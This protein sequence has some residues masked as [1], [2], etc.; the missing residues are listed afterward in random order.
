M[1][2]WQRASLKPGQLYEKYVNKK[3]RFQA[4]MPLFRKNC[5]SPAVP[6]GIPLTTLFADSYSLLLLTL[7]ARPAREFGFSYENRNCQ[8][9]VVG[10]QSPP[11]VFLYNFPVQL[12]ADYYY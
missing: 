1:N 4:C 12:T 2:E 3:Y 6:A 9:S 11:G 5:A 8:W 10:G 7:P